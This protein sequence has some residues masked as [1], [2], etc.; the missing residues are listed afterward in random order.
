MINVKVFYS[1]DGEKIHTWYA[2]V[3]PGATVRMV[4]Q[5][6]P[7]LTEMPQESMVGIYGHTATLDTVLN[8]NDRIELYVPLIIDVKEARKLKVAQK[9]S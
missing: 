9:R 6:V 8:H 7:W 2:H 5:D 4:L 3:K 1:K